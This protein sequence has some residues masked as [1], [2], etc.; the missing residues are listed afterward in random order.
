MQSHLPVR[1]QKTAEGHS[2]RALY[3]YSAMADQARIDQDEEMAQV[4]RT[5]FENITRKRM[6][7]TGGVGSTHRGESLP[8][9]MI[10]RNIPRTMKPALPSRWPCSL[11]QDVAFGSG[12]TLRGLCGKGDLQYGA[13]RRIPVGR[14]LLYEN[15]V[16][17][18][19]ARNAFNASRAKGLQEHLPILSRVKVFDCSC[20]PP[21]LLRFVGSIADYMYSVP[22]IRSMPTATWMR[23]EAET[24]SGRMRL[25]RKP[26]TL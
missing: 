12:R 11:P 16:A 1:Q 26:D 21:N 13:F 8:S 23:R 3:L 14:Q 9:T 15:P 20:C 25:N 19:P 7:I 24:E 22:E 4:C 5:L 18:D 17:A 10:C 2:V 6:Y